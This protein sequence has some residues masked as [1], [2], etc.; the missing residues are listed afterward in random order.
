MLTK[1]QLR[2]ELERQTARFEQ[3]QGGEVI[4]YAAVL[5]TEKRPWKKRQ[6]LRDKAFEAEIEKMEKDRQ[7]ADE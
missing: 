1:E 7:P 2:E 5:P 4:K 3:E 6:S